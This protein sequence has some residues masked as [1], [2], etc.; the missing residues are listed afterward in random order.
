MLKQ[1]QSNIF[2]MQC[3][4]VIHT[5]YLH[6]F[7]FLTITFATYNNH[8]PSTAYTSMK[9]FK[10]SILVTKILFSSEKTKKIINQRGAEGPN[11]CGEGSGTF[12]KTISGLK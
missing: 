9:S 6:S 7:M 4:H 10:I 12:S 5:F 3:F 1:C 8:V 2:K 11:K